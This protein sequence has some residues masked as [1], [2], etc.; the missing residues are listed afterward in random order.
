M[1]CKSF[2]IVAIVCLCV[3]LG[4]LCR[5]TTDVLFLVDSTGSVQSPLGNFKT[6]LSGILEAIDANSLCPETV[7]YGVADYKNYTDGGNYTAYGVNLDQPFTFNLQAALSAVDGLAADGG[8]DGPES[9]LKAMVSISNN[10]LTPTGDLG[11]NGRAGARK[12]LIWTGDMPGHTAEDSPVGY[13]PTLNETIGALAGQGIIVFALN[14][15]DCDGGLNDLYNGHRQASEITDETGGILFCNVGSGRAEIE[16]A[17][18]GAIS[19]YAFFKDDDLNDAND[20]DCRSPGQELTYTIC[21]TNETDDTLE[22]TYIIDWL[23]AGVTYPIEYTLDP[24]TMEM[25]PSDPYYDP[26]THSYIWLLDSVD[27]NDSGCVEI[28]VVVNENAQPGMYLHNV[29]ELVVGENVV[30]TVTKDTLVCCWDTSGILYVDKNA[31]GGNTGVSW[32]NAYTDLNDALF[33]ARTTQCAF[34]YTIYV[35][36]GT[37]APEDLTNGFVLPEG[38]SMYGGYR[39]GPVNPGDRNPK[40]HKTI[41]TGLVDEDEFPDADTVVTMG[42]ETLLDGFTI[43]EGLENAVY[44]SGVDFS[45]E[46]CTIQNNYRYGINAKNGN[47]AVQWCMISLN[48]RDGVRHEGEGYTL[49]VDN[50]WI[51]R[52]GEYG[53]FSKDSTPTVKNSIISESDLTAQGRQGIRMENPTLPPKLYNNTI[54]NNKA[55]GIFFIDDGDVN[56]DPNNLDYPDIQ[57]C[58]VYY[59]NGGGRQ[60]SGN[61]DADQVAAFCCIQDCNEVNFN[62]NDEPMFAYAIDPNGTPDPNNYHLAYNSVCIDQANPTL[63]Y[64]NQVDIDGEGLDRKYGDYVDIGADEVYDCGDD[65]LS[66]IDVHND[67]DFDADGV[68]NLEEFRTFS[69]AW[70]SIAPAD[71]NIVDPNDF[72]NW[73]PACNLDDNGASEDVIDLADLDVFLENWLWIACWKL[74]EINQAMMMGMGGGIEMMVLS[75]AKGMTMESAFP[76][77]MEFGIDYAAMSTAEIVSLVMGINAILDEVDNLLAGNPGNVENL[78]DI[79]DFLEE[80]LADI[81]AVRE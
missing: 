29:A 81:K 1:K 46:Y 79:K 44:G 10:W 50:T 6:A 38:C 43:T 25:V 55:A 51:L 32:A 53:V 42:D 54:A 2:H 49:S 64:T 7:M 47:V 13:Y 28:T 57:N 71:P 48:D 67:L 68:V 21:Y 61:L 73:N 4:N 59:N 45:I 9:Q 22:N 35:A 40:K 56:S 58:I 78:L 37:Y 26:N 34:D 66:D 17:I 41:L 12:I 15:S 63:S 11:F 72:K 60:L 23:P 74:E 5:A 31:T 19:C 36:A 3:V 20:L 30:E 39:G 77:P 33:R 14:P 24:N 27:P 8:G 70:L 65:Y 76:E 75:G 52:N 62:I 80:V 18:I 16:E 69:R